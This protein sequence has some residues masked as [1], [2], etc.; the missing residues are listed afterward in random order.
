MFSKL[1][2]VIAIIFSCLFLNYESFAQLYYDAGYIITNDGKRIECFIANEEAIQT[3]QRVRY[4]LKKRG[5]TFYTTYQEIKSFQIYGYPKHE[6]HVVTFTKTTN[7]IDDNRY[8]AAKMDTLLLAVLVEGNPSLL[9]YDIGGITNFFYTTPDGQP[10]VVLE[11]SKRLENELLYSYHP[12]WDQ[13]VKLAGSCPDIDSAM[14]KR[15]KYKATDLI[16]VFKKINTCNK[17]AHKVFDR[18]GGKN[19]RKLLQLELTLTP[20]INLTDVVFNKNLVYYGDRV[21]RMSMGG[22]TTFRL[23]AEIALYSTVFKGWCVFIE[24]SYQQYGK[25][26]K[27]TDKNHGFR[28]NL[29]TIDIATGIRYRQYIG[30][31]LSFF[32]NVVYIPY[33]ALVNS[34]SVYY[35]TYT[36]NTQHTLFKIK[37]NTNNF[38]ALGLGAQYKRFGFE[39]RYYFSKNLFPKQEKDLW[40]AD[41]KRINLIARFKV[42]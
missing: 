23:G 27:V 3:Q 17:T 33:S 34:E 32:A 15:V 31:S 2:K 35:D 18:N 24:P 13:L 20:G 40:T 16:P 7:Q 1:L 4:K 41:Y 11:Y 29:A 10:P 39:A 42:F 19:G 26:D 21:D 5:K 14:I 30:E 22:K 38:A 37:M 8:F 28:L 36:P 6:K 25:S 9:S 12:F